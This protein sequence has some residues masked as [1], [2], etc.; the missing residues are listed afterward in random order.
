MLRGFGDLRG[1][2]YD[3][4]LLLLWI[5]PS[6]LTGNLIIPTNNSSNKN[7]LKNCIQNSEQ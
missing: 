7:A 2:V 1:Y 6:F 4:M 3:N 5:S